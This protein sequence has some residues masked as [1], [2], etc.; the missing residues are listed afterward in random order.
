MKTNYHPSCKDC[1]W[2]EM[3][4]TSALMIEDLYRMQ[5]GGEDTLQ[6][7]D[8]IFNSLYNPNYKRPS[9]S[10]LIQ[11][12][13]QGTKLNSPVVSYMLQEA[14]ISCKGLAGRRCQA[15]TVQAKIKTIQ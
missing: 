12:D 9:I 14:E 11:A 5:L 2:R 10:E 1:F 4:E 7:D 15:E 3:H 13:V 6:T 8:P